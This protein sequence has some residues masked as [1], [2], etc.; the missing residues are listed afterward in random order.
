METSQAWLSIRFRRARPVWYVLC[1]MY[2]NIAAQ[3]DGM[4]SAIQSHPSLRRTSL[5]VVL[6]SSPWNSLCRICAGWLH[7]YMIYQTTKME[8]LTEQPFDKQLEHCCDQRSSILVGRVGIPSVTLT[9]AAPCSL[10]FVVGLLEWGSISDYDKLSN[11][12][13]VSVQGQGLD[14]Q[15][16]VKCLLLWLHPVIVFWTSSL[17]AETS[18]TRGSSLLIIILL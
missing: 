1:K 10:T 12:I 2:S 17:V 8:C 13:L 3:G 18:W 9:P 15:L 11:F 4:L 14:I 6:D 16:A 7:S 5:S